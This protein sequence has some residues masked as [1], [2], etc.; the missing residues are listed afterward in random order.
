MFNNDDLPDP[1]QPMIAHACLLENEPLTLFKIRF[2][3][4]KIKNLHLSKLHVNTG[5]INAFR[6]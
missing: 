4:K 5:Q 2:F 3:S 1:E 6:L